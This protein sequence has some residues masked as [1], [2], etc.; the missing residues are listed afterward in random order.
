MRFYW[1]N[2]RI[3]QGQFRVFLRPGPGNLVD[4]HPKYHPHEHHIYIQSKYLQ[5]NKLSSLQGCVNLT[6]M[7]SPTA[8]PTPVV[9]PTKREIQQAQLQRYFLECIS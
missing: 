6:I 7:E 8:Q 9:S 5:V 3:K 1:K 4:Y 2:D